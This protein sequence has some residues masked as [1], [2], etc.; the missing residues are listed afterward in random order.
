V[1]LTPSDA[2]SG[3]ASTTYSIDGGPA[4]EGSSITVPAPKDHTWDGV[5]KITYFSVDRAGNVETT[6]GFTARIDTRRPSTRAPYPAS[7]IR[8]AVAR[9]RCKVLDL[10][11]SSS[12][13]SAKIA[14]KKPSGRIVFT[15]RYTRVRTNVLVT[16]KFRCNLAR[17]TYRF[18]VLAKDVAGNTQ[19][20][21]GY[22]R[23]VVR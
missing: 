23:L 6:K 15:G 2:A 22:N 8:Y 18:V 4:V 17:G 14:V 16:L 20:K 21:T 19:Y 7:V 13:A 11:P 5:H 1:T 10:R 9:L 12:Y 3:V